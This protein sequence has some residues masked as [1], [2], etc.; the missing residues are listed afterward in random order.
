MTFSIFEE[1]GKI[2]SATCI[3][4]FLPVPPYNEG[5]IWSDA[6]T[7]PWVLTAGLTGEAY[8]GD[9]DTGI[10]NMQMIHC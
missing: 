4:T 10:W 6:F 7:A 2:D 8:Y 3:F 9:A 1:F 5:K